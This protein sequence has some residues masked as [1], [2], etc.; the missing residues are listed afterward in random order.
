VCGAL[1]FVLSTLATVA[2]AGDQGCTAD[3]N[4]NMVCPQADS[5]CLPNRDGDVVC[6]KPGGGIEIDRFGKPA[7]GPGYCT[8]NQD[9]DIYCSSVPRGAA[10]TEAD[11]KVVCTSS[12]VRASAQM[13]VRPK[14]QK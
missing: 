11:G 8:K 14:P 10:G 7:C 5:T 9:G 6:S 1:A 3:R 4:G 12:C 2:A 13:C